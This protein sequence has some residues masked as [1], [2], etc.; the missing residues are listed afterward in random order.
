[1]SIFSVSST[2]NQMELVW[3]PEMPFKAGLGVNGPQMIIELAK[4]NDCTYKRPRGN[5]HIRRRLLLFVK[6]LLLADKE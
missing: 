4:A 6:G 2:A 1:M 3:D 5:Y